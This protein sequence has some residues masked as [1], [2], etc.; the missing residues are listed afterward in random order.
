LSV[1]QKHSVLTFEEVAGEADIFVSFE[2]IYHPEV[3]RYPMNDPVLAHAFR[4]GSGIG[5]DVHFR[6][7]L[8]WNF[9]VM[10]GE[11]PPGNQKSFFAIALHELGK[12]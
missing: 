2:R 11:Q 10:F 5:G 7:D 3:D 12:S 6:E 9:D 1:W 4:P 8:N